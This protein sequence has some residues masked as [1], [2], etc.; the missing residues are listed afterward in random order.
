MSTPVDVSRITISSSDSTWTTI[1][2][3]SYLL[4]YTDGS[5]LNTT[6]RLTARAG[7]RVWY[8]DL[9]RYNGYPAR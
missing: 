2:D 4:V 7:W 8:S 5:A 6:D 9:S 1:D 3:Y